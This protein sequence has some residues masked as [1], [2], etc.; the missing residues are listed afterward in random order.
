MP[1]H[2]NKE[3]PV[4]ALLA[5]IC[6]ILIWSTTPLAIHWS[7]SSLSFVTASALRMVLALGVCASVLLALRRPLVQDRSDWKA[8]AV[9]AVGLFPN[10]LIVYW[11]AQYIPSGLMAVVLGVTPFFAGL[12]S[13]LL[14]KENIL[15][16]RRVLAL[17]LAV[18][19][20][21][22]IHVDQ[23]SAVWG[24]G[25]MIISSLL[26]ALSSVWLKS[27]GGGIDPLR[28]GTGVLLLAAPCFALVWWL[29]DGSMPVQVD[30]Q[31]ITG[32]AYLVL[33][34]SVLGNTLFFYVLRHYTVDK[35]SLI[36][37]ITPVIALTI[38]RLVADEQ[39]SGQS[40]AGAAMVVGALALYQALGR[41]GLR[42]LGRNRLRKPYRRLADWRTKP[43][44]ASNLNPV[45]SQPPVSFKGGQ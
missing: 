7:N 40:V 15:N 42:A 1:L 17:V 29:T 2:F 25:G 4:P 44:P 30:M 22:V 32:V 39:L 35:V 26:F 45:S 16:L 10:M 8:F 23:V 37:L 6:V 33:A 24:V 36:T 34:G 12:F 27:L 31:S 41:N 14:L 18:A 28:Q 38:G 11:S 19:G 20:L 21:L 5:Y 3:K 9:G 43:R 13:R